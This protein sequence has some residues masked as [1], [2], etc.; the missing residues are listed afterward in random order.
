M[1]WVPSPL[2]WRCKAGQGASSQEPAGQFWRTTGLVSCWHLPAFAQ[3]QSKG[4]GLAFTGHPSFHASLLH[5]RLCQL[6]LWGVT[7]WGKKHHFS[8]SS[9]EGKCYSCNK[10]GNCLLIAFFLQSWWAKSWWSKG[11]HL[12]KS[13]FV[14]QWSHFLKLSPKPQAWSSCQLLEQLNLHPGSPSVHTALQ[15]HIANSIQDLMCPPMQP[16]SSLAF[17]HYLTSLGFDNYYP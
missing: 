12:S 7:L 3:P 5:R 2:G 13:S 10:E 8:Q 6:P 9:L 17:S 16:G 15:A 11:R 1:W 14:L 4:A